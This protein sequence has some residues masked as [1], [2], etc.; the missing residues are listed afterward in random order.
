MKKDINPEGLQVG[1]VALQFL[2]LLIRNCYQEIL[3]AHTYTYTY[4]F[5]HLYL[6]VHTLI[7]TYTH[8][9]IYIYIYL[10]LHMKKVS[11][12]NASKFVLLHCN[13]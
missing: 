11:V 7:H 1:I 4:T 2:K 3:H 13:F 8:T 10:Y 6:Y 5:I 9:Y 12:T